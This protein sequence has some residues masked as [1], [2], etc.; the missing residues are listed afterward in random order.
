MVA[1]IFFSALLTY[2]N[3]NLKFGL[4]LAPLL[5]V[6]SIYC[7]SEGYRN[8]VGFVSTEEKKLCCEFLW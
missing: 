2:S 7:I 8:K 3:L 5:G 1:M 6:S 4:K